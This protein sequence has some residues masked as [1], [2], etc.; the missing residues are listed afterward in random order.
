ALHHSGGLPVHGADPRAPIA[1]APA[2]ICRTGAGDVACSRLRRRRGRMNISELFI[3]RPIAT[4][5]FALAILLSGAV[6][7][8]LLPVAPL[9][10]V[11]FPTIGASA[12]LPGAS[13]ETMASAVATPLERRFARIAGVTEITSTSTLGN[14]NISLQFDLDRNID[15]AARD[16]QAAINAA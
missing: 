4:S 2:R 16:V 9:P 6:A 8:T 13:P 15:A 7:Y 12:G 11:D 1:L 3:R 10:R 14:T 5:L